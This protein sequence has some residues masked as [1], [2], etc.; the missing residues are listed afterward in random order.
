MQRPSTHIIAAP[1]EIHFIIKE[2]DG[3]RAYSVLKNYLDA[4]PKKEAGL[5]EINPQS[6][7]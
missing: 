3:Q 1:P 4:F 2:A 6:T 5:V 7:Q